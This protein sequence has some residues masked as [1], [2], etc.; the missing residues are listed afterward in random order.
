M[1]LSWMTE[2]TDTTDYYEIKLNAD[3]QQSLS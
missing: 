2:I 3:L 1:K